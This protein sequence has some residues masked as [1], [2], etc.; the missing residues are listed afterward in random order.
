MSVKNDL[1][2]IGVVHRDPRGCKR[3]MSLLEKI[4]CDF[5]SLEVSE[6]ALK[7]RVAKGLQLAGKVAGILS[8]ISGNGKGIDRLL[9]HGEVQGVL[10]TLTIPF[11]VKVAAQYS[12]K[13]DSQYFLMDDSDF[14]KELLSVIEREMI[15]PENIITLLK[16]PNF[17]YA[18]SIERLYDECGRILEN[19]PLERHK[20]GLCEDNLT[21]NEIRDERIEKKLRKKM[22]DLPGRWVHICGFTHILRTDGFM[23]MAARF[24]KAKRILAIHYPG[25]RN[26][27]AY[28]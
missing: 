7:W 23:N 8:E 19:E 6:Y 16:R 17:D 4:Q 5:L 9:E 22:K 10:N 14:S 21:I 13:N 25:R 1:T 11:E 3:V 28:D 15:T 26:H 24:P 20:L 27:F 18:E 12:Y 2:L